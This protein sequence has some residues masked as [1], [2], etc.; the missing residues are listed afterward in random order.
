M[1]KAVELIEEWL[2]LRDVQKPALAKKHKTEMAAVENRIAE[3]ESIFVAHGNKNPTTK[4]LN[5][6]TGRVNFWEQKKLTMLDPLVLKEH[7]LED[8]AERII[9]LQNRLA[10]SEVESYH[11]VQSIKDADRLADV[12]IRLEVVKRAK[13]IKPTATKKGKFDE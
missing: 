3:L 9:L 8:P 6:T 4:G 7:I 13:V 1:A 10:V 11:D 2:N 12:G 5:L